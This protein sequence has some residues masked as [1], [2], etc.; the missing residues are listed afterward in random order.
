MPE[1]DA[2]ADNDYHPIASTFSMAAVDLDN[3]DLGVVVAS[4]IISVGAVVP[5]TKAGVGAVATQSH[6]NMT[7]G[8]LGLERMASGEAPESVIEGLTSQD[9]NRE[10]RQ[11]GMVDAEGEA[12]AFTGKEVTDWKGH[13]YEKG[14]SCQGNMLAG[15]VVLSEMVR[16][17]KETNGELSERLM[18]ALLAGDGAGG[19][20]RG[21]QSAAIVVVR[22]SKGD[23][24]GALADHYLDLRVDHH[25]DACNELNG[26][27][28][29]W[30]QHRPLG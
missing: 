25:A 9:P 20:R 11:V 1:E 14:L 5:Y 17:F 2:L 8:P 15:E 3:G 10:K 29:W 19:D 30:K 6:A 24:T 16:V 18:A 21:R 4:R 12:F 26:T 28:D 13:V 7:Y 27:F 23:P 22:E